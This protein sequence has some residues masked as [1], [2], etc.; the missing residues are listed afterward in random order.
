[1][2]HDHEVAEQAARLVRENLLDLLANIKKMTNIT[3]IL[4]KDFPG[5]VGNPF[6]G[7]VLLSGSSAKAARFREITGK[8]FP[9]DGID[10]RPL[11]AGSEDEFRRQ[12]LEWTGKEHQAG[13]DHGPHTVIVFAG[14]GHAVFKIDPDE[15]DPKLV[16]K[17]VEIVE[18]EFSAEFPNAGS[19][20]QVME[21]LP[22]GERYMEEH[23]LLRRP[24]LPPEAK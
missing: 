1:M 22:D 20:F 7:L 2:S 3:S 13:D 6:R 12:W 11:L 16:A 10:C 23:A 21:A 18:K 15:Q 19:I 9:H 4:S 8:G 14:T 24:I 17:A 5:Q